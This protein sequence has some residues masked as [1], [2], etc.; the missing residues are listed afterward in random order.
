MKFRQAQALSSALILTILIG[1]GVFFWPDTFDEPV[2][3]DSR[4]IRYGFTVQ[5]PDAHPLKD[6]GFWVYA[7]IHQTSTQKRLNIKASHP[8]ELRIDSL[9]NEQ[10]VFNLTLPP[11]GSKEVWIESTL[12]MSDEPNRFPTEA[13]VL[14]QTSPQLA[15]SKE[16]EIVLQAQ[17]LKGEDPKKNVQAIYDWTREHI[18][19]SG[20]MKED[21]GALYA[22]K[23]AKGDC[24]EYAYLTAALGQAQQLTARVM[25]GFV[26]THNGILSPEDYHNWS[27]FRLNNAWRLVDAQK[28][29]LLTEPSRYIAMRV[30]GDIENDN[31]DNSQRFYNAFGGVKVTMKS[32]RQ[33]G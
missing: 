3:P 25:A 29:V 26:V 4:I 15:A 9:G 2:Y 22:L 5:N 31:N 27:E 11:H 16:P 12:A 10:L 18:T 14:T 20:Y 13:D 21:R 17:K 33:A 19:Y 24:T 32:V 30:L 8:Y 7:P 23:S 6:A 28:E 1:L